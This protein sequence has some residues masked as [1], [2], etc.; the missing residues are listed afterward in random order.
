MAHPILLAHRH[1][2]AC[3][4]VRC[5]APLCIITHNSV[6]CVTQLADRCQGLDYLRFLHGDPDL[7]SVLTDGLDSLIPQV[8]E[9]AIVRCFTPRA[10]RAA[11]ELFKW[12]AP[13]PLERSAGARV[14]H[15][16]CAPE[17]AGTVTD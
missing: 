11:Y 15:Q 12:C 7:V 2:L 10:Q 13:A 16:A 6:A 5:V 3:V 1:Q 9:L 14:G 17:K 8:G 4:I